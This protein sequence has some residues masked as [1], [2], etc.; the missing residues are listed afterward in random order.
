MLWDSESLTQWV[1]RHRSQVGKASAAGGWQVQFIDF[2]V[3]LVVSQLL[4]SVHKLAPVINTWL[5]QLLQHHTTI[6]RQY[7]CT[8]WLTLVA[9]QCISSRLPKNGICSWQ[10]IQGTVECYDTN[11]SSQGLHDNIRKIKIGLKSTL[12][13]SNKPPTRCN[14]FSSLLSWRLFTAQHVSG[15]LTPII[16]SSTTAVAASGFTLGAWW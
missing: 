3:C 15:V 7:W 11:S 6:F 16:R 1:G 13:N 5:G 12:H 9:L 10:Y 2:F 8:V 4:Q 14:N